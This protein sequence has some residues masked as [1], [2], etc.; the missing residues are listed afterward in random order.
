MTIK[1]FH[2]AQG[3]PRFPLFSSNFQD[4]LFSEICFMNL[5]NIK[6]SNFRF[7]NVFFKDYCQVPIIL[8][9]RATRVTRWEK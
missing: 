3:L 5:G 7:S 4:R 1:T 9:K 2:F 6:V 8:G